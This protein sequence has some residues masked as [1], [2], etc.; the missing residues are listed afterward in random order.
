MLAPVE[1]RVE[2]WLAQLTLQE[3]LALVS[4][5]GFDTVGVPRLGI[6]TLR[7]T[8]G[9]VGVRAGQSTAF[10]ASVAL[11]A[12]FD[13]ALI[14]RVGGALGR[15]AKAKGKNV[16][17]GPCVNIHRAPHGG[18][19]F[20]SFGEDPYLAGRAAVAY[21]RGVQREGVVATVKHFAAN[22][23]E[24]DR[25]TINV[26]VD[27]RALH[28]I[29]FP[30]FEAAVKEAGVQAVM[31]SYNKLNGPWAC[32]NPICSPACSSSAGASPAW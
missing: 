29:Y 28:E 7:M 4:G 6:P 8:D 17:L 1:Q 32:E 30:A 16:L 9:P 12:T 24:T 21:I 20:E 10:P 31:C 2:T 3:K 14:E 22:N 18:R 15:E 13:P 11:A 23:Q 25:H 26:V 5:T 19:N 27:E